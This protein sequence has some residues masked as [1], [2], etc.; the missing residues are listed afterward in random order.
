MQPTALSPV[1]NENSAPVH[2]GPHRRRAKC[3]KEQKDLGKEH[4]SE[5][6]TAIN[7]MWGNY[8]DDINA[9]ALQFNK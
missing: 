7:E 3:T 6:W 8:K 5:M 9:L 1:S 2:K 4:T